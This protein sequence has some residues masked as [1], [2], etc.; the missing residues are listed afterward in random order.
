M[1]HLSSNSFFCDFS[2]LIDAHSFFLPCYDL[3]GE[4][5]FFSVDVEHL[6]VK[7][8]HPQYDERVDRRLVL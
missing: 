3:N 2:N 1:F 7:K 5:A 6:H 8:P 4:W